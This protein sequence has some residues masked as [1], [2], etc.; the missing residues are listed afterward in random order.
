MKLDI[1]CG[2]R[3]A[4]LEYI[5]LDIR[6]SPNVDVIA[7]AEALPFKSETFLEVYTRRCVQHIDNDERVFSEILRVLEKNGKAKLIV[8]SW[9]GWLFF[10]LRWLFRKKPYDVFH[11]YTFKNLEK[12]FGKQ[13]FHSVE[14]GKIR[15]V[16]RFG[17]DI[18]LE[19]KK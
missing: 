12:T 16:R 11:I 10:Q 5:G 4:G 3:K 19:A 9:R 17:Y 1:G 2:L 14:L 8:A 7:S 13:G 18:C 15:S 6:K